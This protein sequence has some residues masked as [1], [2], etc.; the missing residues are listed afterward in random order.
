VKLFSA[1]ALRDRAVLSLLYRDGVGPQEVRAARFSYVSQARGEL[2]F[3]A[4]GRNELRHLSLAPS[5][6]THL[7]AYLDHG[8]PTLEQGPFRT[9]LFLTIDGA[10]LDD[11]ELRA[12]VQDAAR[13]A[14]LARTATPN[15][16]YS[17][18]CTHRRALPC[19][20]SPDRVSVSVPVL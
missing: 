10:P 4:R 8:R 1:Q 5:T 20:E 13:E 7:Q 18:G 9:A 15:A 6:V 19:V 14:G 16:L 12:L 17:A 3:R 11:G 2:S